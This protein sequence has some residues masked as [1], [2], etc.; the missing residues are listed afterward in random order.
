MKMTK[1][2]LQKYA[3]LIVNTGAHVQ[4]GQ[5]VTLNVA[6]EISDFAVMMA[7]ECYKAG[8]K[9]VNFEWSCDGADNLH[10]RY[11]DEETLGTVLPWEEAKMKQRA[12]D[13]P[14]HIV[15]MSDDPDALAGVDIAKMS[16]IMQKR[17]AVLKPYRNAMN[18][19]YQW[20]GAGYASPA[21]AKKVF[22]D[23]PE[24]EAVSKLWD[25]ILKTVRVTEDNDAEA[26][27][28]EHSKTLISKSRW[29]TE[30]QFSAL[31]YHSANGTDFFVELIPGARFESAGMIN[32]L[33]DVFYIPNM[34]TEEVFTT[35]YAGKCEGT[36]VSTKPLSWNGQLID[37]FSITFKDGKAVSCKAGKGQE[38]LEQMIHMDE[39]SCMLGEVALVP[40]ESPINQLGYLFYNTLYDENACCHVAL[41]H[42]FQEVLPNG[43][44]L[45]VEEAQAQGVNDSMIHVDFMVGSD[46]LSIVGIKADGTEVPVF[47]N[48]TWA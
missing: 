7:E 20:C 41:G 1:D 21:W 23:L 2:L 16:R 42:G 39:T 40:K 43:N 29:M 35:P 13:L 15:I 14:V 32:P 4:P 9:K 22:P 17:T 5:V 10:Y 6:V 3:R 30:Q 37:D 48:G 38:I 27:W 28:E 25:G 19:K 34:P 47:V 11:A 18:G 12:E 8:A 45:S 44:D 31:R 36:L 24:D 33:N 26:A 46:D